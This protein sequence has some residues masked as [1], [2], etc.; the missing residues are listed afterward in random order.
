M[1]IPVTLPEFVAVM[2]GT[3]PPISVGL[4]TTVEGTTE[5]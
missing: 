4:L 5:D 1:G 3:L 2:A